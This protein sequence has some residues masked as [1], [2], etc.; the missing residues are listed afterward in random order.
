MLGIHAL[1]GAV[2]LRLLTPDPAADDLVTWEVAGAEAAWLVEDTTRT[3]L[4]EITGADGR[5]WKRPAFLHRDHVFRDGAYQPVGPGVLRLRHTPRAAGALRWRLL[6]PDG[7]A[8]LARGE[9]AVVPARGATGPIHVGTDNP[10]LLAFADGTPFIPIGANICW[11]NTAERMEGF[12]TFI[13]ALATAGGNHCRVWL[14]SW[15]GQIV[16]DRPGEWRL[17]Q[18]WLI[19]Q[20][21]TEARRA[22]VRV[23]LV[24]DNHTD[25]VQGHGVP[26]GPERVDRLMA[27]ANR[28][29]PESYLQKLRYL[30]ARWGADDT[31]MAWELFNELDLAVADAPFAAY[32]GG[33]MTRQLADLDQDH[34]LRTVS[35]AG[36]AWRPTMALAAVDMAQVH[37]YVD[38][39]MDRAAIGP[40]SSWDMVKRM[41]AEATL[42]NGLGKPWLVGESGF[43]GENHD[44]PGNERDDGG[45]LLF[46]QAWAGF[47]LGG[48]GSSMNWWWDV[49]LQPKG[50]WR[51]YTGLAR[52]VARLDWRDAELRPM[53]PIDGDLRVIGWQ[54]PK[55]ALIWP[56]AASDT[57]YRL[58]VQ[59][60]ARPVQLTDVILRLYGFRPRTRYA[61]HHLD[62]HSGDE[63]EKREAMTDL[64]GC[65]P[66]TIP[67]G[68]RDRVL[69]VER[70]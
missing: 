56:M 42:L 69:W 46:Q 32:W 48:C 18:A 1:M 38:G 3:P 5:E 45:F 30:L 7:G 51:H 59:N 55:Q 13:T 49:Y 16:G 57:W 20:V 44:N 6:A 10:R 36:P 28:R 22:G 2:E 4:L 60:R 26:Y 53:M 34:R 70:R 54:G 37:L 43:Q 61:I 24:F 65:L 21:L 19:D 64:S 27:F 68:F 9:L 66:I 33:L 17:D 62:M 41:T 58:L 29:V 40:P 52:T 14:A 15:C 35:W 39:T 47:M 12:R 50:L 25:F 11:S 31:V 63:H 8:E 23:T 67:R